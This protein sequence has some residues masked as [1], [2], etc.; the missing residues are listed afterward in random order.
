MPPPGYKYYHTCWGRSPKHTR[1]QRFVSCVLRG[2]HTLHF[3]RGACTPKRDITITKRRSPK[4]MRPR[5]PP[6]WVHFC[7]ISFF[8]SA[9]LLP[10]KTGFVTPFPII[11]RTVL[12][13]LFSSSSSSSLFS[14][15]TAGS[16][17]STVVNYHRLLSSPSP[18]FSLLSL[19]HLLLLRLLSHILPLLLLFLLLLFCS[20]RSPSSASFFSSSSAF[21]FSSSSAS[22]SRLLPPRWVLLL[23]LLSLVRLR[24][25]SHYLLFSFL[26]SPP[27]PPFILPAPHHPCHPF[28]TP[29]RLCGTA[30]PRWLCGCGETNPTRFL[31]RKSFP[32]RS[33]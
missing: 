1:P 12:L 8:T 33:A 5:A 2:V 32:R 27:P 10:T 17:S 3:I 28:T 6:R 7:L 25:T 13:C 29:P 18:L 26:L 22:P 21:R 9:R 11:L 31:V 14:S 23:E 19:S 15:T 30:L 16:S 4:S 20:L 24:L